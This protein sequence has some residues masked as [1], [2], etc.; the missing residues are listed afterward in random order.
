[1]G[2]HFNPLK[3]RRRSPAEER[4]LAARH[5]EVSELKSFRERPEN[6]RWLNLGPRE[7]GKRKR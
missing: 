5:R 1:M 3:I 6:S 4:A 7:K 2:R